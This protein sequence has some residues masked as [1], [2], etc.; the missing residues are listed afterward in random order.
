VYKKKGGDLEKKNKKVGFENEMEKGLRKHPI[1]G[2]GNQSTPKGRKS[3]KG[4]KSRGE[5]SSNA[6]VKRNVS[7]PE[8]LVR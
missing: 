6:H 1:A 8:P 3:E 5:I 7:R 4:E 2:K